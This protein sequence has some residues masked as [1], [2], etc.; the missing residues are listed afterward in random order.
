MD[1]QEDFKL[2]KPLI[3]Y[4]DG[5]NMENMNGKGKMN[6]IKPVLISS[7]GTSRVMET[8]KIRRRGQSR[9]GLWCLPKNG[10]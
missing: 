6:S 5:K 9:H 3:V 2:T 7:M 1:T 8:L 10:A 4:W